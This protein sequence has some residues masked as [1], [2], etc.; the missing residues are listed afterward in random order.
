[1]A[2]KKSQSGR[3]GRRPASQWTSRPGLYVFSLVVLGVIIITFVAGPTIGQFAGVGGDVE[4]GRYRGRPIELEPGGFMAQQREM[5]AQQM[6]DQMRRENPE[7]AAFQVWRGAFQQALLHEAILYEAEQSGMTVSDSRLTRELVQHPQFQ[8]RGQFSQDRFQN[9]PAEQRMNIR[10]LTKESLIREAYV[11]DILEGFKYSEAEETFFAQLAGPERRFH[12]ARFSFNDYPEQEVRAF[13]EDNEHRMR[14]ITVSSVTAE[15]EEEALSALGE[16]VDDG[17]SF[18]EVARTASIDRWADG[19]GMRDP[20]FYFGMEQEFL[21]LDDLD[22]LFD[23]DE[24]D[25]T[26]VMETTEGY[27]FFRIDE[28]PALPDFDEEPEALDAVRNYIVQFESG[29][30][31]EYML[32]QAERFRELAVSEGLEEALNLEEWELESVLT[33]FFPINIGNQQFL[34]G[35]QD[36]EGRP[37]D[38]LAQS[39]RFFETAFRIN[40]GTISEPVLL[41]DSV[42]VVEPLEERD[43][44]EDRQEMAQRA[45]PMTYSQFLSQDIERRLLDPQFVEDN[46]S[47]AFAQLRRR[48]QQ[49]PQEQAPQTPMF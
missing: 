19:G 18:E 9:M 36:E 48:P 45:F 16:H 30:I 28:A 2:A 47:Q 23:Q 37:L 33:D 25:I 17:R 12:I 39:E 22:D 44:P 34:P 38:Q 4:F 31:E 13:A 32:E 49:P 3:T 7:F 40:I 5:I 27:A 42:I 10:N 43:P 11:T 21:D 26:R 1:M 14:R 24:G 46:F 20:Q 35:V 6:D 41:R 8:E 15:T 29:R